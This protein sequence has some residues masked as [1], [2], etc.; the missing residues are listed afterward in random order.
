MKLGE[1]HMDPLGQ[2][3]AIGL[4]H[5]VIVLKWLRLCFGTLHQKRYN[6]FR[7]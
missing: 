2:Q 4:L 5:R 6:L 7:S 3:L 1:S